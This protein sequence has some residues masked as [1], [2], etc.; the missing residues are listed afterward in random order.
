MCVCV[1]VHAYVRYNFVDIVHHFRYRLFSDCFAVF[2]PPI[3]AEK[4]RFFSACSH[5][6]QLIVWGGSFFPHCTRSML[7][8]YFLSSA[9]FFRSLPITQ[10]LLENVVLIVISSILLDFEIPIACRL[11]F[12]F[13]FRRFVNTNNELGS[14]NACWISISSFDWAS[15]NVWRLHRRDFNYRGT[16]WFVSWCVLHLQVG[17]GAEGERETKTTTWTFNYACITYKYPST[18]K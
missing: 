6:F 14:L 7:A 16:F 15:T 9:I 13:R 11:R 18:N 10:R 2:H 5:T 4:K 17:R 1:H 12:F 3:A 8:A